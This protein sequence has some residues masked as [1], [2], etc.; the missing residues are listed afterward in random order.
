V[1]AALS[2]TRRSSDSRMAYGLTPAF[3]SAT[4]AWAF[5]IESML[6]A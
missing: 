2:D 4:N 6:S 1:I 3:W 5:R